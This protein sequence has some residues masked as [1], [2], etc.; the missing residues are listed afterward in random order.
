ML[1][2]KILSEFNAFLKGNR[3]E[4]LLVTGARQVGKTYSIR[5]FAK[6][7]FADFVEIN[8]IERPEAKALFEQTRG[9]A[10][11]FN[12]FSAFVG[13]SLA[14]GQ[15]LVFFDEVQECPELVTFV[16]FLVDDGRY[17]YVLSG[18]LLGVE[19]KDVRS[20]PVGY[21]REIDMFPLDFEEFVLAN[22]MPER[23]IA[24]L[25]ETL[26]KGVE[27]DSVVDGKMMELFRLYL[28]VGGMPAVVQ[29]YVETGDIQ[30]VVR[31]Q[32]VILVLYRKDAAKYDRGHKMEIARAFDLIP[33]E[34]NAQ[35]KRF[36]ANT[37]QPGGRFEH[38]SDNFLW[39]QSAG[40]AIPVYNVDA[41]TMP[42]ELAKKANLFKLF[43]NDVGLL[44]A[45]FMDGIQFRIL[46]GELSMNFGAIYENFVAQELRAHG[47][48]KIFYF[49]SKKHGEVDFLIERDGAVLPVEAKSGRDY[50]S[51]T[52]LDNLL[53][54]SAFG[55]KKAL[56]LNA[57]GGCATR[58]KVVYRP[59]YA[60]M[61]LKRNPL[62]EMLVYRV[63]LSALTKDGQNPE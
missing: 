49:N 42:L 45:M 27:V 53:A 31:E 10:D 29:T 16:K 21:L 13:R 60:T 51:H 46:S 34:L 43:L 24:R 15:T 62:P 12:R 38:M 37:L 40:M 61:F 14:A 48:E 47:F 17:R 2:R 41:P 55:L 18:S 11:F 33:S 7:H 57:S 44:S 56:V 58:G 26:E 50:E 36:Y 4:A 1:R 6:S 39:L 32:Q 20:V 8:F 59:V 23:V 63:D 54:A 22:G 9:V 35:N 5:D 28:V 25:R 30:A 52:A 19:M 3:K